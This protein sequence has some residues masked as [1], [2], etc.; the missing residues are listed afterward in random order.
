MLLK[1]LGLR[2]GGTFLVFF[3]F[4]FNSLSKNL[5]ESGSVKS[6]VAGSV[7]GRNILKQKSKG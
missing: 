3:F 5:S 6:E 7:Q 2:M 1:K 4:N